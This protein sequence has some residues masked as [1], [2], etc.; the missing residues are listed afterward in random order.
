MMP[1]FNKMS[2]FIQILSSIS[3]KSCTFA[4]D[5]KKFFSYE[6]TCRSTN[7]RELT[8]NSRKKLASYAECSPEMGQCS[9]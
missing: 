5:L 1:N 3:N 6:E 8:K 2:I 4:P 9:K 7:Y